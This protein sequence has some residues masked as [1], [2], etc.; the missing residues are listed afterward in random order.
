[1]ELVLREDFM[2]LIPKATEVKA[3]INE[4]DYIELKSF[5][6]ATET[7]NKTKRQQTEWEMLFAN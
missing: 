6:T 7:D 4:W 3:T 1:M 2:N 5:C